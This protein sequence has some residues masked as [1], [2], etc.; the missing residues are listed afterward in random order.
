MKVFF[1]VGA[2]RSGTTLLQR[3]L[4]HHPAIAVCPETNLFVHLQQRK[5]QDVIQNEVEY[6]SLLA[7]VADRLKKFNDPA[8]DL[9]VAFQEKNWNFPLRTKH[10]LESFAEAYL[11]QKGRSV[12]GEKTP[13]HLLHLPL[14]KQLCP[15]AKTVIIARH[16]LDVIASALKLQQKYTQDASTADRRL[17]HLARLVK[18]S[19]Y[20]H[21]QAVARYPDQVFELQ[22][23][24]LV[25][26]PEKCLEG[27]CQF[28]QLEYSPD[29]LSYHQQSLV[30]EGAESK[31]NAI[32]PFLE[33]N[34]PIFQQS[35]GRYASTLSEEQIT[36]VQY[37]LGAAFI[38]SLPYDLPPR[39]RS[40]TLKQWKLVLETRLK[41][42]VRQL[43]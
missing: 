25:Q 12:L 26:E 37:C 17:A 31:A 15:L 29:M 38:K 5:L 42:L 39:S 2:P 8:Y 1:I 21:R 36:F 4:D 22:Y 11:E 35:I 18:Q 43:L 32:E 10:L 24:Q 14:I 41:F 7:A 13:E 6:Q 16:P 27:I 30:T 20:K 33:T 40:L 28:L 19:W 23:E 34:K 3:L 9:V